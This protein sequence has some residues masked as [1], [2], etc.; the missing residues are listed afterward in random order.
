MEL[1]DLIRTDDPISYG[2][3]AT[4]H[5]KHILEKKYRFNS[6]FGEEVL[7]HRVVGQ[8]IVLPRALCP[9]GP[10]DQRVEGLKVQ[11]PAKPTPKPDQKKVFGETVAFLKKGQ[12]G[13]VC[14]YTG[15]GK[16]VL[17][18]YV[19]A[20][21]GV[22]TLVVTTKDDI[23]KQWIDGACGGGGSHNF[24]GL[25][26]NQVGE[27][28]GSKV[29]I[30]DRPFVVSMIHTLSKDGK[31]PQKLLN[32]FGLIIFDECHRVPAE[33]FRDVVDLFPAK[34]RL[35]M[36]ATIERAD[37]KDLLLHAHIG[38]VRAK[39]D[40]QLRVPKVL[41]FTST[42]VCPRVLKT[43]RNAD[44]TKTQKYVRMA[45]TPGKTMHMEKILAED[46]N[47]NAD[48]AFMILQAYEMKR[49]TV[50]FSTLH[51]H[52]HAL[53]DA[54]RK[55]GIPRKDMGFYI[56]ATTKQEVLER[57]AAAIKP[58]VFTT[59]GMMGEGTNLPWLDCGILAMPRSSVEQPCGRIRREY[60]GKRDP[61]WMDLKDLDSPVFQGYSV[62]RLNWYRRIGA[63]VKA[64]S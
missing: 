10:N 51:E 64:M 60:E 7:L 24:L 31:V 45:H 50:V 8:T 58:V 32:Q 5:H 48:L 47:R 40:E 39:T 37:G 36:S 18:Y 16:T 21:M 53:H 38:P 61:V 46:R 25:K 22:K 54:A 4:Y 26:R 3:G 15:W 2:A 55:L 11:F 52:L 17:G 14:A 59:F 49:K 30:V 63:V 57:N 62:N 34:L 20:T 56:G 41:M 1:Q 33:S 13:M 12:S 29:Q 44:G 28:R 6:R 23:Y 19:A 35:G 27:I 9:V 42:W 43:V